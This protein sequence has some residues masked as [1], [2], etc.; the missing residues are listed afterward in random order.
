MLSNFFRFCRIVWYSLFDLEFLFLFLLEDKAKECIK[1]CEFLEVSN[2]EQMEDLIFHIKSYHEIPK[3]VK[4]LK[5]PDLKIP[6]IKKVL[7]S[8]VETISKD[9]V[10]YLV[11]VEVQRSI[12]RDFIFEYAK[13]LPFGFKM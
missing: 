6:N 5:F 2:I 8:N 3:V 4:E 13:N 1:D 9:V 11:E 12:E 7:R 10:D